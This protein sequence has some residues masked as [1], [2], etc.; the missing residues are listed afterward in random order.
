MNYHNLH[1]NLFIQN[2]CIKKS[3][4]DKSHRQITGSS[5]LLKHCHGNIGHFI[6]DHYY[7][8]YVLATRKDIFNIKSF[9]NILIPGGAYKNHVFI[10]INCLPKHIQK[11]IILLEKDVKYCVQNAYI[12]CTDRELSLKKI[13]KP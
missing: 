4:G 13:I 1:S 10:A 11:K 2:G 9:D 3:L 12:G 8:F 5:L 6:N 7:S